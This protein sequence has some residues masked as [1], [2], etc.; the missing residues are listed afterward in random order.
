MVWARVSRQL[1]NTREGGSPTHGMGLRPHQ[2]G[3]IHE[4]AP[5]ANRA[6]VS[7]YVR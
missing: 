6:F 4:H 5:R 1:K 7:L 3:N 2:R